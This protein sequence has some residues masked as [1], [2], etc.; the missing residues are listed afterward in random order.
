MSATYTAVHGNARSRPG[1][2]P[3][4][5]WLLVGFVSAVPR[6]ERPA[7]VFFMCQTTHVSTAVAYCCSTSSLVLGIPIL[8]ILVGITVMGP[9][10]FSLHFPDNSR[11]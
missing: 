10:V 4:T 5:S 3:T 6:R 9:C 7:S 1:I 11:G 8:A 2:K